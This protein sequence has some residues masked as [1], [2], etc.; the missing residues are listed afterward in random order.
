MSKQ[1]NNVLR[2]NLL[3]DLLYQIQMKFMC[4]AVGM[5]GGLAKL[6]RLGLAEPGEAWQGLAKPSQTKFNIVS[7]NNKNLGVAQSLR[8]LA[9]GVVTSI[10]V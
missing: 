6:A 10:V 3:F 9:M 4:V 8:C 1:N 7:N 2:V 5:P